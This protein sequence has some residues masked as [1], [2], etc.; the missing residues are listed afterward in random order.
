M[1]EHTAPV[2]I[3]APSGRDAAVAAAI[4]GEVGVSSTVCPD[5]DALVSGL[6]CAGGAIV[7]EE[8]LLHSDRR[9]LAAW[10]RQQPPWSELAVPI[11]M[12]IHELTTNA[13]KYGAFSTPR[14]WLE[15]EWDV[16]G[17]EG[18]RKLKLWWTER[19]GPP[20]EPPS[21]KGFGS[22]LIQ[23]LLA[24][25]CRAE[26]DFA[27]DRPGLRFRMSVSLIRPA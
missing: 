14:G 15:V 5:L 3:L 22:S 26:I 6:D 17:T 12:A 7:T 13:A 23:R 20:V 2:L 11:G 21:Q 16:R 8:A 25:Q 1:D 27:Y 4:L 9:V 19:D 24:T 18:A 10:I